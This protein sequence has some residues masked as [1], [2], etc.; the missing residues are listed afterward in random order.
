MLKTLGALVLLFI[1]ILWFPLWVQII[2]YV[3]VVVFISNRVFFLL[4]ALFA[5]VYYAPT[6]TLS[7]YALKTTIFVSALLVAYYI[8]VYKTRIGL[9]Y[10]VEKK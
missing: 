6:A 9:L 8:V 7:L 1:A 3:L 10:G 5:D 4:P 2:L